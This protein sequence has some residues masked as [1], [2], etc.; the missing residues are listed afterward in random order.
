MKN[1]SDHP[2]SLEPFDE[3]D[4]LWRLLGESRRPEPDGWFTART[5]ARC[6]HESPAVGHSIFRFWRW[7]CGGS[8]GVGLAVIL[9]MTQLH[10]VPTT[11]AEQK[12]K[13]VQ[14]AFAYV[15]SLDSDSDTSS[16][17]QDSSL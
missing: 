1:G 10:M 6:R 8:F 11:A 17:W 15:A 5:V 9:A 12:Q 14:E 2:D 7:A 13:N 3:S 16:T 4:S